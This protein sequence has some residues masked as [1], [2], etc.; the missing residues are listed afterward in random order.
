MSIKL[1]DVTY[2]IDV[3]VDNSP[4]INFEV[5]DSN[6]DRQAYWFKTE[7]AS[8]LEQQAY[9]VLKNRS[10]FSGAVDC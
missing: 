10:E 8:N 9:N 2:T 6:G 3:V 1:N 7:D 5:L 4:I